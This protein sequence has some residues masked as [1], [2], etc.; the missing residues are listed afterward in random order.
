M[1]LLCK[2][3]SLILVAECSHAQSIT[4]MVVASAGNFFSASN[5]SI[6]FTVGEPVTTTV[7][8]FS[9]ILTQGFQQPSYTTTAI[10]ETETP[11]YNLTVYPN[12]TEGLIF[13]RDNG[14]NF[15][16]N[17]E[18]YV[19]DVLGR[20]LISQNFTNSELTLDL[21]KF[22]AGNYFIVIQTG[23]RKIFTHKITKVQ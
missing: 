11:V 8:S 12:P 22:S 20:K 16:T 13:I 18:I 17:T 15:S 23:D 1:K 14:N 7:T 6:S 5:G 3:L 21:N 19:V 9:N 2:I 10:D 4:P